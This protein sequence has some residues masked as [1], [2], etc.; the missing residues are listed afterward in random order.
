V[1]TQDG[2]AQLSFQLSNDPPQVSKSLAFSNISSD[3]RH[4]VEQIAFLYFG[5]LSLDESL[6]IKNHF[7][8]H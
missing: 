1:S 6:Y 8:H 7:K 3:N 2:L 5:K 4:F